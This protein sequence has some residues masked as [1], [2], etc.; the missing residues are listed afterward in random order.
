MGSKF[1]AP[2]TLRNTPVLRFILNRLRH[3]KNYSVNIAKLCRGATALFFPVGVQFSLAN[4][5]NFHG[6]KFVLIGSPRDHQNRQNRNEKSEGIHK[7]RN[8][9]ICQGVRRNW[10]NLWLE[11]KGDRAIILLALFD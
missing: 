7:W 4:Q 10:V 11:Y 6:G 9:S 8:L 2:S 3:Q 5:S 1:P